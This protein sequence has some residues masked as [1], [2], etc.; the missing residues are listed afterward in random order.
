MTMVCRA[1]GYTAQAKELVGSW[2]A[3]Y[4]ALA[5]NL[6]LYD[7][8]VAAGTVDRASA[9]QIVY[10]ALT[11]TLKYINAD[12]DTVSQTG[13]PNM[14]KMLGG[15]EYNNGNPFVL[16]TSEAEK[17]L[18][19]V[20]EDI[21]QWVTA[22]ADKDTDEILAVEVL[23]TT[24]EGTFEAPSTFSTD[25][26]DYIIKNVD[27][28][29]TLTGWGH[30]EGNTLIAPCLVENGNCATATTSGGGLV[31][32]ED[33]T[34][35]VK[36]S[37]KTITDIYSVFN[38]DVADMF[39][40]EDGDLDMDKA[41]LNGIEF[42]TDKNG[43]IDASS[44]TLVGVT[45][46]DKIAENNVVEIYTDNG[47]TT[48]TIIKVAV[49]TKTVTGT[50]EEVKMKADGVTPSKYVI[51]GTK[52]ASINET[53]AVGDEGTAYLNYDGDI[54]YWEVNDATADN[55][56]VLIG[57]E[58]SSKFG[59]N[60]TS[61]KL[62]TKDGKTSVYDCTSTAK[63]T[64]E[65]AGGT[66]ATLSA[67]GFVGNIVKYGLNSKGDQITKI[68]KITNGAVSGTVA[69]SKTNIGGTAVASSVLVFMNDGGDWSI[70]DF[71]S[72]DDSYVFT[73]ANKVA[74]DKKGKIA[75]FTIT[76]ADALGDET[77]YGFITGVSSKTNSD[78][79][80]QP[81]ITG[82]VDGKE[83]KGF[84]DDSVLATD[85]VKSGKGA[86]SLYII[87]VDTEGTVIGVTRS[88]TTTTVVAV[89]GAALNETVKSVDKT[90]K[91]IE[92]VGG[93][94]FALTD[95]VVV[96]FYDKNDGYKL[97]SV[98]D[99]K[100]DNTIEFI[101]TDNRSTDDVRYNLWDIVVFWK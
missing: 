22:F 88:A 95:D 44:F 26:V 72:V 63:I 77:S 32:G 14:L 41:K 92:C 58:D 33:Y 36:I 101:Q 69:K 34:L 21:G 24:I 66:A 84:V 71:K 18:I 96:Y 48:G 99:I 65:T 20:R 89:D 54:A 100:R 70:I 8:V 6:D 75:A 5:Q 51:D 25:D 46:L 16:T 27:S 13:N 40:F 52:Y 9:A 19:N 67:V 56:G 7:D 62:V 98:N 83:F 29:G 61:V 42:A 55:Y 50:C 11:C 43:D 80:S 30:T 28:T 4:I 60:T 64:D 17:A 68:Q 39:Q 12:G 53:P 37:G 87:K 81:Y 35:A 3:N 49:G 15:V 91:E 76:K 47:L 59:E 1:I 57:Y 78:G 82:F 31:D 85:I 86:T 94:T 10:N 38:L 23:S 90:N 93:T 73:G 2:P 45:S 97:S 74:T 79:N